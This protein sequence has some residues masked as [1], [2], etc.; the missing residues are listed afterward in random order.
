[1]ETKDELIEKLL[2]SVSRTQVP[3]FDFARVRNQILDRISVPQM[4]KSGVLARLN[5]FV[6][7]LR[8][9][10]GVLASLLI[11]TSLTLA[12]SVAALQS[13]PGSMI[14]PL[15][16]IVENIQLRL[17]PADQ[18]TNL[19]LKFADNRAD[20]LQQVLDQNQ[21]GKISNQEAETIVA[22]TV[23]ELQNTTAAAITA[24]KTKPKSNSIVNKLA[25][26]SNKLLAASV[27]SE[28]QLKIELEKAFE[29]TKI[30]Q[31]EA[32]KNLE[33]AGLKVENAPITIDDFVKASGKLTAV[34]TDSVSIGTAKFL[35]TKDTKFTGLEAKDLKAGVLVDINGQI[36]D[37]KSYAVQIT[38]LSEIKTETTA[39][40]T[41][42][43][44]Q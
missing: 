20:E 23:K 34:T 38:K 37:N 4:A 42:T 18:R 10:G 32:I 25:N 33:Q 44:T 35:L 12:T 5:A 8:M 26:I 27:Q 29:S 24:N 28:G 14:Y 2:K 11:V 15:K 19:Q 30:T 17:A 22:N 16:K 31:E 6:P 41:T 13:A 3:A 1:M 39:P 40:A 7:Y 9:G 43:V 36:K 21:Q